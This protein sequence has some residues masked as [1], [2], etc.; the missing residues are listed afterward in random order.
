M[1]LIFRNSI[2]HCEILLFIKMV[3]FITFSCKFSLKYLEYL[4]S[5]IPFCY[6][7]K[8]FDKKKFYKYKK[9]HFYEFFSILKIYLL[10]YKKKKI[11]PPIIY[12][13]NSY[14]NKIINH[15]YIIKYFRKSYKNLNKLYVN[16]LLIYSLIEL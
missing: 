16:N 11:T 12:P 7:I 5:K 8:I 4:I 9:Y 6:L 1:G 10:L 14:I 13:T 2:I 15:D 3:S